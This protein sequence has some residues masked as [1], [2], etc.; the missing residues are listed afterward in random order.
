[1]AYRCVNSLLLL[2]CPGIASLASLNEYRRIELLPW[3]DNIQDETVATSPLGWVK[4]EQIKDE[5]TLLSWSATVAWTGEADLKIDLVSGCNNN[6]NTA[7]NGADEIA[8]LTNH[9]DDLSSSLWPAGIAGAILC[10][11]PSFLLSSKLGSKDV[12]ELGSGVG[13]TGIS[14][15]ATSRLVVLT[16][17]DEKATSRISSLIRRNDQGN[18]TGQIS[19][20]YL[21]WRDPDSY[22][23]DKFDW[24]LGSDVAYY[25]YLLRP[26]MDTIQAHRMDSSVVMIAGQANRASQWDLYENIRNGCYNQ[27]TD[28]R[29]CRW[30]GE[31]RMLLFRLRIYNWVSSMNGND[32]AASGTIV[33]TTIP[34][35]VLLH[36]FEPN[37]ISF[38][39]QDW[40]A[41]A[42]DR[43]SMMMSF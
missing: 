10:R 29:E 5:Q 37:G 28:E 39:D 19:A 2:F 26:L 15:G 13:L 18:Y 40:I 23:K 34:M 31:T 33:D 1:M 32:D 24:I 36:E 22:L 17:H 42:Q 14:A 35:A 38:S 4:E 3:K 27:M 41:T 25:F 30:P 21:E 12:L 16:D 8:A 43:E 7:Q 20:R 6:K 11:S 9:Q